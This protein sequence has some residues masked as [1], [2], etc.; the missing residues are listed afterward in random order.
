MSLIYYPIVLIVGSIIFYLFAGK[1]KPE[2]KQTKRADPKP[3]PAILQHSSLYKY[4]VLVKSNGKVSRSYENNDSGKIAYL[5]YS[6]LLRPGYTHEVY[7]LN[8]HT[9]ELMRIDKDYDSECMIG[10]D[11][12]EHGHIGYLPFTHVTSP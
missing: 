10:V 8:N 7:I 9:N 1:N 6:K 2:V 11:H 12:P 3:D 5:I 4:S